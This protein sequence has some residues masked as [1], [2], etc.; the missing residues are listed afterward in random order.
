[1]TITANSWHEIKLLFV[2]IRSNKEFTAY[3]ALQISTM[4]THY[5]G[6]FVTVHVG[7]AYR[8]MK[9]KNVYFEF[10]YCIII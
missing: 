3:A 4:I 8:E 9:M 5:Q 1:M 10:E 6:F 7:T 2:K